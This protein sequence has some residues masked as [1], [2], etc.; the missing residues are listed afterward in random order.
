MLLAH[1]LGPEAVPSELEAAGFELV[2]ATDAPSALDA[3]CAGRVDVSV[4]DGR[5]EDDGVGFCERLWAELPGFPV[6][7]IGPNDENLVTRALSAGADDYIVLPLRPAELVARI[8]AVLRRAPHWA[9]ARGAERAVQVGDVRLEPERHE[10]TLRSER[11]HLPLREFELLRLLMENVGI[12]LPR[13]TL[14]TRLWGPLA[15]LD[16]TS[17]EVHIRRLRAKL[18]DD[19]AAPQRIVT[20]RGIG[21]RY[22]VEH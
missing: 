18:E 8:R 13:T 10:V 9:T 14:M 22:Q 4:V 20:V 3:A 1:A 16:S 17:L 7:M 15:P 2:V 6:L 5:F 19:P 12:V 11:L 21:Y